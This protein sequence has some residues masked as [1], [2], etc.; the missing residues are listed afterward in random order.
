MSR[1]RPRPNRSTDLSADGREVIPASSLGCALCRQV[2]GRE[3]LGLGHGAGGMHPPLPV[4]LRVIAAPVLLCDHCDTPDPRYVYTYG[5]ADTLLVGADRASMIALGDVGGKLTACQACADALEAGDQARLLARALDG[6][7]AR[8]GQPADTA[9]RATLT[10]ILAARA[11]IRLPG[12]Q[13]LPPADL[14][15][16]PVPRAAALPK[17]RDRL[18]TWWRGSAH[19]HTD[20]TPH[21]QPL[22]TGGSVAAG[23]DDA[24]L[25]WVGPDFTAF[26]TQAAEQLPD[27]DVPS[28]QIPAPSGLLVWATPIAA[29]HGPYRGPVIAAHWTQQPD[30]TQPLD[31]IQVCFYTAAGAG[32]SGDYLQPVREQVGWLLPS[33]TGYRLPH[34]GGHLVVPDAEVGLLRMLLATWALI[35]H[36]IATTDTEAPDAGTRRLYQRTARP[37]PRV[38]LIRLREQLVDQPTTPAAG[39]AE[40]GGR[41]YTHRWWV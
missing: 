19:L 37:L 3:H 34:T 13:P 29:A 36:P 38:R 16:V 15:Y 35:E 26:A 40:G 20:L 39:T 28:G 32:V 24:V 4:P 41:V 2:L 23:L 8:T 14:G 18:A 25:Y 7:A 31:G 33:T 12:R 17:V 10:T 11:R 9:A 5:R 1:K 30:H 27:L 21:P 22:T 6:H